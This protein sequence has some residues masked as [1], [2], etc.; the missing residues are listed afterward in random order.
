M[1]K[2]SQI[3]ENVD[4]FPDLKQ[5][6]ASND[7]EKVLEAFKNNKA[8]RQKICQWSTLLRYILDG[9][10]YL[11]ADENDFESLGKFLRDPESM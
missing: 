10:D 11:E 5:L 4:A 8:L 9:L 6:L 1:E 2:F 3:S 7:R